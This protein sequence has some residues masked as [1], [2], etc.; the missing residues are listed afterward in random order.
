VAWSMTPDAECRGES[1]PIASRFAHLCRGATAAACRVSFRGCCDRGAGDRF[2]IRRAGVTP[3]G[4]KGGPPIVWHVAVGRR[5]CLSNTPIPRNVSA[6]RG[7]GQFRSP[8]PIVG[9][10][11][12]CSIQVHSIRIGL[13][14]V[15]R[16][17]VGEIIRGVFTLRP[18]SRCDRPASAA[19]RGNRSIHRAQVVKLTSD[20]R[21]RKQGVSRCVSRVVR[22]SP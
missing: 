19:G 5:R 10:D 14:R 20:C 18:R 16:H 8:E 7:G 21:V 15:G 12:C 4:S 1:V 11:P 17:R 13:S 3:I 2:P 22:F 6:G 9:A